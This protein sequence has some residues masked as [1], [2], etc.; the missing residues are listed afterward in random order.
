[1][2][3]KMAQ[4]FPPES[5]A[6]Q[7]GNQVVPEPGLIAVGCPTP[8]PDE[9]ADDL[10]QDQR[11]VP[12]EG[13]RD[14]QIGP[15][16]P[17]DGFQVLSE[18]GFPVGLDDLRRPGDVGFGA[19][20]FLICGYDVVHRLV[21]PALQRRGQSE[22]LRGSGWTR[23]SWWGRSMSSASA[24]RQAVSSRI[25]ALL[26][27]WSRSSAPGCPPPRRSRHR[28]HD[29]ADPGEKAPSGRADLRPGGLGLPLSMSRM[30][31]IDNH[32]SESRSLGHHGNTMKR[33]WLDDDAAQVPVLI[34]G[35]GPALTLAFL[36]A[37]YGVA[38][39][40]LE[41]R[42]AVST[43]SRPR[44]PRT[45]DGDP[46]RLRR[47]GGHA[48]PRTTDHSRGSSGGPTWSTRRSAKS[49]PPDRISPRSA[50]AKD[51]RSPRTCSRPSSKPSSASGRS[52]GFARCGTHRH[53]RPR[54]RPDRN[55]SRPGQRRG[56]DGEARYVVR[57]DGARGT[58]RNLLGIPMEG[59]E[60]GRSTEYRV[61]A[62]LE[63]HAGSAP[64]MYF[65]AD[66]GAGSSPP[67]PTTAGRSTLPMSATH[68]IQSKR[69]VG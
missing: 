53:D 5:P 27:M 56:G 64:R 59:A 13:V 1:M 37:R 9:G 49:G 55:G 51:S 28:R 7:L 26:P 58:I 50:P 33:G 18:R 25:F 34:I 66:S 47:R 29:V 61:R 42:S 40:V 24:T 3:H 52:H 16:V 19:G 35:G 44:R 22:P 12:V 46:P 11:E 15:Q 39:T 63:R 20:C 67:A 2:P 45:G 6:Q 38:S 41:K 62:D 65:L 54:R 4:I 21:L 60:P 10:G 31:A 36:L 30:P 32:A 68:Q 48:P 14:G 69:S 8:F 23:A 43:H 57:S 17:L